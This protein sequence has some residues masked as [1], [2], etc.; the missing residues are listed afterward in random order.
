MR[1]SKRDLRYQWS[2]SESAFRLAMVRMPSVVLV[3]MA[4]TL[5]SFQAFPVRYRSVFALIWPLSKA[6]PS[7]STGGSMIV[8]SESCSS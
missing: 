2:V 6:D 7:A 4:G 3:Q 8:R 1:S 5:W